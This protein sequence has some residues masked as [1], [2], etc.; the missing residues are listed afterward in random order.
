MRTDTIRV[1]IAAGVG[2]AGLAMPAAPASALSI[3]HARCTS[4]LEAN[5][6][7]AF[8]GNDSYVPLIQSTYKASGKPGSPIALNLLGKIDWEGGTFIKT[9]AALVGSIA[10]DASGKS[11][12]WS[13]PGFLVDLI[14]V[15]AANEFKLIKL[16]TP[17]SSGGWNTLTLCAGRL[18]RQPELSHIQFCGTR[19]VIP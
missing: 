4:V 12:T 9:A 3:I 14:S 8:S 11:G 18:C 5:G 15:K 7:C 16:A 13:V 19:A 10:V 17:A 2:L 6:R 1:L